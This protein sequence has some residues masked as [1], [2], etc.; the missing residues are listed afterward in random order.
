[1]LNQSMYDDQYF[2]DST[3]A[4]FV[5]M[6]RDKPRK[7]YEEVQRSKKKDKDSWKNRRKQEHRKQ[8]T[9]FNT[10]DNDNF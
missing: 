6:K 7:S 1:M 5:P 8:A 4:T 3:E 9:A 10:E 2:Q